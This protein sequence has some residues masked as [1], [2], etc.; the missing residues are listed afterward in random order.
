MYNFAPG[1]K[2][3]LLVAV[4]V[5]FRPDLDDDFR[6][7]SSICRR[8]PSSVVCTWELGRHKHY[9]GQE[10]LSHSH[11]GQIESQLLRYESIICTLELE[12]IGAHRHLEFLSNRQQRRPSTGQPKAATSRPSERTS[13]PSETRTTRDHTAA[14]CYLQCVQ[15]V[16]KGLL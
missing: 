14:N 13:R 12:C 11:V 8:I 6:R 4:E 2:S 16:K 7:F 9:R 15:N 10:A 1:C 3:A 5:H